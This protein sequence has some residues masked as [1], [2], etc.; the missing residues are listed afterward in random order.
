VSG[1]HRVGR[2]HH[3]YAVN[4]LIARHTPPT[5]GSDLPPRGDGMPEHYFAPD[6]ITTLP[7]FAISHRAPAG[8]LAR[9]GRV[10]GIILIAALVMAPLAI[11]FV[12]ASNA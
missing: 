11:L 1:V 7:E 5:T 10:L 6:H 4:E 2:H 3:P 8:V 12:A 9:I